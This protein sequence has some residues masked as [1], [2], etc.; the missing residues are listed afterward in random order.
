MRIKRINTIYLIPSLR[1]C[2]KKTHPFLVGQ[3][4]YRNGSHN[5]QKLFS[6]LLT[7]SL[8]D[9]PLF[10]T[11]EGILLTEKMYVIKKLIK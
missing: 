1:T 8:L 2:N 5:N 3:N 10:G 11:L 9:R 6:K 4:Q 7:S